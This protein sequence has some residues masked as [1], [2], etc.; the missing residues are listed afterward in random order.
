MSKYVPLSL[1]ET[2]DKIMA[3]A[4]NHADKLLI[5]KK[6]VKLLTNGYW[7]DF[8]E[9]KIIPKNS[10]A[11]PVSF[12][13]GGLLELDIQ[14]GDDYHITYGDDNIEALELDA[15][16][17]SYLRGDYYVIHWMFNEEITNA[18]FYI[19][20]SKGG[21]IEGFSGD[22]KGGIISRL[23]RSSAIRLDFSPL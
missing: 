13:I 22:L 23:S 8:L 3:W 19:R 10:K 18:K 15:I 2:E 14:F 11:L 16:L 12:A 7:N 20:D 21:Y 17:E 5:E 6:R 1:S 4:H 9:I